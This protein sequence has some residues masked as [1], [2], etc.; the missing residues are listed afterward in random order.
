M[1]P[2]SRPKAQIVGTRAGWQPNDPASTS[3]STTILGMANSIKEDLGPD[4]GVTQNH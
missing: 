3:D 2:E 4:L 1:T